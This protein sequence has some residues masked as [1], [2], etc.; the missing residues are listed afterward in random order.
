MANTDPIVGHTFTVGSQKYLIDLRD[1]YDR[2]GYTVGSA[3]GISKLTENYTP[4]D[5]DDTI[6]VAEGK[7]RGLLMT[8]AISHKGTTGRSKVSK[9]T[10][11]VAKVPTGLVAAKGKSHNS[12]KVISARIPR[13]VV[14]G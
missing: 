7:A 2:A 13:R 10:V 8:I 12:R 3:F 5:S 4:G 9:L 11:P 14:L 6:T 1:V